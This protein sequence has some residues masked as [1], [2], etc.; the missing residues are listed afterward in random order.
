MNVIVHTLTAVAVGTLL[1]SSMREPGSPRWLEKQDA[2]YLAVALAGNVLLHCLLDI[3]PHTYPLE[4][5]V[6]IVLT[7]VLVALTL[8]VV[9]RRYWLVFIVA[10]TG[11]LLP[12]L[13]DQGPQLL[14]RY[15][16]LSLPYRELFPWH[17]S[18]YSGSRYDREAWLISSVVHLLV[19]GSAMALLAACR[20]A[21]AGRILWRRTF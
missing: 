16:H 14:N 18:A 10:V 1:A 20:K 8:A 9:R 19:V 6:D 4:I 2:P 13:V 17:W 21:L 11:G 7:L 5:K 15:F 12:D 3:L